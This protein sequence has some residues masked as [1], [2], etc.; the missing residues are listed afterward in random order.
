[1]DVA[2]LLSA[3]FV[4]ILINIAAVVFGTD[5][6]DTLPDDHRRPLTDGI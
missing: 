1:M 4:L 2:V 5:S 3:V 6:R